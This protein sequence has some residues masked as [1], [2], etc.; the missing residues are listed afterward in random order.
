MRTKQF[1]HAFLCACLFLVSFHA[2][3]QEKRFRVGIKVNPTFSIAYNTSKSGFDRKYFKTAKFLPGFQL[4]ASASY[5]V[6]KLL[7][8]WNTFLSTK[9]TGLVFENFTSSKDVYTSIRYK[10]ISFSNRLFVGYRI[11]NSE[12]PYYAI[13][14]GPTIGYD[15]AGISTMRGSADFGNASISSYQEVLPPI[16][17]N[18]QGL[19]TG[20]T[21][22][23]RTELKRFGRID[24]GVSLDYFYKKYPAL[25]MNAKINGTAYTARYVPQVH[26]LS[27]DFIYYFR[28]RKKQQ[29]TDND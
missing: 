26:S 21:L 5:H 2:F 6:N 16:N 18:L 10:T 24:Y 11:K 28:G 15:I 25:G 14:V 19:T 27:V 7:F 17:T 4:G 12:S 20:V 22:K 3:S 13:F 1:N 29:S 8:E 9:G 23:I